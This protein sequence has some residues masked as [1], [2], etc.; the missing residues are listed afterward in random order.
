[1]RVMKWSMIAL[2]VTAGTSQLAMASAQ[3]D[4][5]GF[6]EDSTLNLKLRA[7]YMNRDFK[8]GYGNPSSGTKGYREDTG[9]GAHLIY[10]SGFTQGTIGV[11]VDA[12][13][14]GSVRIDGGSGRRGNGLFA[15]DGDGNPE[16]SQ[17]KG[18][19][20]V[21]FRISDTV[22]K[23]GDQIVASPVFATDDGRLLPEVA[24][25]T[26]ITSN[27]IE[28]LTLN[29]GHFTAMSAQTGMG[30]DTIIGSG[31]TTANIA[32][33]TY[34]FTKD[35]TGTIAAS[36]VE[37]YFKKQYV[38]LNYTLPITDDQSMNFDFNAYRT[39]DDGKALAG[40]ADNKVASFAA[41]YSVGAHKFTLGYQQ[42]WGDDGYKYGVDGGGT[43]F[44]NNSVQYS[45]FVGA[46]EKSAQARYDLN[47][48]SFGVPGLSFMTRY[49]YGW[50]IQ[51][52]DGS[53]SKEHEWDFET[54]YVIQEG[55][56]KDMS[57]RLRSAVWRADQT[58]GAASNYGPSNN[59]VRFIVEYPLSI[60]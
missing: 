9:L 18:A 47:M 7:L 19:G 16:H 40:P 55:P 1:M 12:M 15:N 4:S 6:V 54:K 8:A 21:K 57:F 5:K 41:A 39:K 46:E 29:V 23:I 60:M 44:L 10:E 36:D 59:D 45:D 33:A 51:N 3:D 31:L 13:A 37:D 27:E 42:L 11:G 50:N 20:A 48:A 24:S 17:S 22:L 35:F 53:E 25:G 58:Y 49:I 52:D 34:A 38:N 26:S 56:V 32:G 28:N 30:H 14:F 43:V 2:A